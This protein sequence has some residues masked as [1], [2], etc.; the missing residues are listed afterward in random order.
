MKDDKPPSICILIPAYNEHS[1]LP[2][3]IKEIKKTGYPYLIVNDGSTDNTKNYLHRYCT[4][5]YI[6]YPKNQGKGFAIKA[7][8]DKILWSGFDWILIMD[9][10]GQNSIKDIPTFESALKTHPKTKIIIGNRLRKSTGMPLIRKITNKV[11][12]WIISRLAGIDIPDTQCGFRLIRKDVF[13]LNLV[14]NRF[15]FESEILLKASKAGMKIISIPIKCIYF[16]NRKSKIKCFKD[17][18]NFFKMIGNFIFN[19]Y[20]KI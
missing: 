20:E 16:T 11:M 10:D 18:F 7:G 13:K 5:Y 4:D 8:A 19:N 15:E 14:S 2:K 9:A 6:T 1:T 3:V 17:T 12:S